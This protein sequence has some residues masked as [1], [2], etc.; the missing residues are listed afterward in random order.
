MRWVVPLLA[1][2]L[3]VLIAW[4]IVRAIFREHAKPQKQAR[5]SA[6]IDTAFL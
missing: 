3:A 2:L 1:F 4:F 5:I 6:L